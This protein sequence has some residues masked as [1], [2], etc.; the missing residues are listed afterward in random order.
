MLAPTG[1]PPAI[2][3][4]LRDEVAKA[5]ASPDVVEKLGAAGHGAARHA[6]RPNLRS[7]CSRSCAFYHKI[8]KDANIKPQ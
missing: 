2:V 3:Q 5:V 6:A 4:K 8:V 7:T 1:T